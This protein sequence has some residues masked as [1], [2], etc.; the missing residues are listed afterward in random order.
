VGEALTLVGSRS[1]IFLSDKA[2]AFV[3]HYSPFAIDHS[4]SSFS[5]D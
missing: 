1:A 5:D 4:S 3:E 2:T